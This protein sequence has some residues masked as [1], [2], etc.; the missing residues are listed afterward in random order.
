ML[1][2][3]WRRATM[4]AV[5]SL[6]AS[7][8]V[9]PAAFAAPGDLP[10]LV[11]QAPTNITMGYFDDHTIGGDNHMGWGAPGSE[12]EPL[13]ISFQASL[14]NAGPGVLQLCADGN[15]QRWRTARQTAPGTAGEPGAC[16]RAAVNTQNLHLRYVTANHSDQNPSTFNR[17]HVMD[18]QRFALVP[19]NA[20]GGLDTSRRTIWDTQW[21]TC[22]AD[23]A[24]PSWQTQGMACPQSASAN[25]LNIGV[26][27]HAPGQ[28]KLTQE[29]A[30]DQALI[31]F[32]DLHLMAFSNPHRYQLVAMANPYGVFRESG[33]G[34]GSV[35]CRNVEITTNI[36][37]GEFTL[38]QGGLPSTC[39]VPRT[40]QS[41]VTGAG[42]VDPLDGA[43]ADNGCALQS[44]TGHCWLTPP[45]FNDPADPL[46]PHP[47][48]HTN[49]DDNRATTGTN[50]VAI[51]QGGTINVTP[52]S[53]GGGTTPP[54]VVVP[55][56]TT[57]TTP[58]TVAPKGP[59][60]IPAM[61]TA[62]G[63]SHVR[64]ALRRTFGTLPTTASV[65]CI[66]TGGSTAACDVS[67]RRPGGTR[68]RGKVQV[69][70]SSDVQQVRWNYGMSVRR[71]KP[72]TR[73]RMTTRSN[74][75]G[76]VI[77]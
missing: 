40:M 30:P 17:W 13:A 9:A 52:P 75:V 48:S 2:S 51:A 21:G 58:P 73:A 27:A 70:F 43:V 18:L 29:G 74:V 28:S 37:T 1:H 54:P 8:A 20:S 76:G 11:Q 16:S 19:V 56:P 24:S 41:R 7:A 47:D 68:Y 67:W 31:A 32:N 5:A 35:A 53:G 65:S 72:G 69:W 10:D 3:R 71:T 15:D 25:N 36:E 61:T 33:N 66:L 49:V 50:A 23:P 44:A 26:P 46:S 22:L 12:N 64:A 42:G 45:T 63:R 14:R 60:A 4:A 77:G 34:T 55:Q 6:C 57:P 39:W 38:T 62:M 59:K